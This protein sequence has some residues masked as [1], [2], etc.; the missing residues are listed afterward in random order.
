MDAFFRDVRY[1]LRSW[2][3]APGPIAAALAALALGI[4]ANTAIFSIVAGV[5]LRPLP[6]Q[7][8]ERLV[9]VWQDLRARGG[10]QKDWISPGLFVEWRERGDDVRASRRGARLGAE[11]HRHRRAGTAAR[12]RGLA[13]LLRGARRS[14]RTRPPLRPRRTIS[15][16]AR[17]WSS[18]ATRC[19]DGC[20]T[21]IPAWS[22]ARSYSTARRRP[23]SGSCRRGSSRRSSIQRTSGPRSG[24]IPPRAPR[25]I[26]VLRVLGKLKPGVTFAQAQAGMAAI[27]SQLETRRHANGS[28]PA[29]R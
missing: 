18:S 26:I 12:R 11:P 24:S 1:A 29:S 16:T 25:G 2:R 13:G 19:G 22:A 4:G 6:Y 23:S 7:N 14:A 21:A 8:P 5:L 3:R 27:A 20:S 28:A 17:R 10:P 9:M 15:P